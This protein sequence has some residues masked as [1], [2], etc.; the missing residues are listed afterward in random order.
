MLGCWC[1]H[2]IECT[3]P[4][5]ICFP[6]AIFLLSNVLG[7]RFHVYKLHIPVQ[8]GAAVSGSVLRPEPSS[9]QNTIGGCKHLYDRCVP[10]DMRMLYVSKHIH[11]E[12]CRKTCYAGDLQSPA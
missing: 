5:I 1:S 11:W 8:K 9:G 12:Q 7:L 4:R 6:R 3:L 2:H 10:K